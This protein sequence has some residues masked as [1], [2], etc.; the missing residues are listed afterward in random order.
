MNTHDEDS[1]RRLLKQTLPPI[2][3][4]GPERDLWPAMIRRLDARP[5]PASWFDWALAAAL[6]TCAIVFPA[7][8]PVFLYYL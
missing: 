3:S 8:I 6:A 2:H 1:V 4:V 7:S 5:T